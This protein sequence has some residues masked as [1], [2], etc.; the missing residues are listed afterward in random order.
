VTP[1]YRCTFL[2]EYAAANKI[3]HPR[4]VYLREDQLLLH[5]DGWLS[6]KFDPLAFAST[7]RELEAAQPDETMY[8]LGRGWLPGRRLAAV[9]P[10]ALPVAGAA[11]W[12]RAQGTRLE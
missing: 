2:S 6:R 10:G 5:L 11:G 1:H 7:V 4:A 8:G 12:C 9:R 3:S